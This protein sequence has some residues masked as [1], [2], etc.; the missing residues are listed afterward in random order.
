[1]SN[2]REFIFIGT[3]EIVKILNLYAGI[4]GNRKLWGDEHEI[5]AVEYNPQIAE[6]YKKFFPS[7]RVVV[8]DAHQFLIK[9]MDNFDFIWSSPPCPTHSRL[10]SMIIKNTGE[11]RYPDMKLYQE[12]IVLQNWFKGLFVVENVIPYYKPLINPTKKLHRHLYWSNFKIGT[13]KVTNERKHLDIKSSSTIYSFNI[14]DT[15]IKDKKKSLKNMVD[16]ELSRHILKRAIEVKKGRQVQQIGLF[17]NY[18]PKN[19]KK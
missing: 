4:G 6:V 2:E 18:I 16:P 3:I 11:I 12:I 17:N 9:E 15:N 14:K 13:F 5:T 8:D 10:N 7:D 1:M 19:S